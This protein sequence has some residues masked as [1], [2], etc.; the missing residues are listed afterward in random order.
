MSCQNQRYYNYVHWKNGVS[1]SEVHAELG[2]AEGS[3]KPRSGRHCEATTPETIAKVKELVIKNPHT[4]TRELSDFT[5]ISQAQITNI[6]TNELGMCKLLK[7]L[8]KGFRNVITDGAV[9]CKVI[10]K[11]STVN[12]KYYVNDVLP[13]VFDNFKKKRNRQ[14]IRD[15]MLHH[16]NASSHTVKVVTKYLKRECITLLPHSPYSSDLAPCNFFLFPKLKQELAGQHF[17]RIENLAR[18]VNSVINTI[19]NREYEK[20]FQDWQN[21][22]KHCIEV[23]GGYFEGMM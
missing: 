6:L 15:V 2:A 11:G 17:E 20:C 13:T 4:T 7:M 16:D 21:W 14:T 1:A 12:S 8:Q 18:A 10:K 3:H 23:G 9:A 22:L 5:G 19:P